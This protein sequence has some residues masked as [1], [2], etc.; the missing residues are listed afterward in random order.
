MARIELNKN[1]MTRIRTFFFLPF[2]VA[3]DDGNVVLAGVLFL[4]GVELA[5]GALVST[6]LSALDLGLQSAL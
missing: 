5:V 4:A 2:E 1:M 3:N 6:T